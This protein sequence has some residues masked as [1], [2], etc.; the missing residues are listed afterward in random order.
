MELDVEVF[1]EFA[2]VPAEFFKG[3][4]IVAGE[5][6]GGDVGDCFEVDVGDLVGCQ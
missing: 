1:G 5:V 3:A 4:G 6:G 2:D